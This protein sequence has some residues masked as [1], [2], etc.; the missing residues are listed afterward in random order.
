MMAAAVLERSREGIREVL[1]VKVAEGLRTGKWSFPFGVAELGETPEPALR[2]ILL[3][4]FGLKPHLNL[5]QPPLDH[6]HDGVLYRWR[7][8]FG[9]IDG[10]PPIKPTAPETRWVTLPSLREYMFEPVSQQVVDWM[11]EE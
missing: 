4:Q 7:F 9:E 5:G 8:V 1:I 6:E 2:R 10:D 3:A 11:L